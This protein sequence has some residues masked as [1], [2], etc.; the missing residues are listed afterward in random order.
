MSGQ[1][2]AQKALAVNLQLWPLPAP[3]LPGHPLPDTFAHKQQVLR[4]PP[5]LPSPRKTKSHPKG[6]NEQRGIQLSVLCLHLQPCKGDSGKDWRI[7][8]N[9]T[10]PGALPSGDPGPL[11]SSIPPDCPRTPPHRWPATHAPGPWRAALASSLQP[12]CSS[13]P[14][15]PA[16]TLAFRRGV[17]P[18]PPAP[19]AS[20][21]GPPQPF[22]PR[23]NPRTRT[24]GAPASSRQARTRRHG[25][26][27][28]RLLGCS[29]VPPPAPPPSSADAPAPVRSLRRGA[30][31][32]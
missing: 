15:A 10:P 21:P 20:H 7:F 13:A 30:R 22:L 12:Q 3:N 26:R 2:Q 17:Y 9:P 32:R 16:V 18:P 29:C 27:R 5:S 28:R 24:L 1:Q 25:A 11:H 8:S 23:W 19:T 6:F 31:D 14:T 4:P